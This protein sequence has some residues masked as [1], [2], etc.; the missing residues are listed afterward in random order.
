[1]QIPFSRMRRK[2]HSGGLGFSDGE[3]VS[4]DS[5]GSRTDELAKFKEL[6]DGVDGGSGGRCN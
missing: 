3:M 2:W 5:S 6:M 4:G 1:M